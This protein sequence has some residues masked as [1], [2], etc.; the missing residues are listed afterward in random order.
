MLSGALA[1]AQSGPI[2][3]VYDELGRL[4]GVIDQNG[5][6][7]TYHYDAVGNLTGITRTSAGAVAIFEF[8][9]NAAPIGGPV[10]LYG[11]GFS[12]TPAQNAVTINGT[13]ATVTS[14]TTT[15]LVITVPAGATSGTLAVTT[16]TGSASATP[17]FPVAAGPAAPSISGI[18]PTIGLA[19]T[20]VTVSGSGFDPDPA[21]DKVSFNLSYGSPTS[22]TSTQVLV[23]LPTGGTSGRMTVATPYGTAASAQDFFVPPA[24]YV[25]T[26][27]LVTD[28]MTIGTDKVVTLGTASKIGLVVFDMSA[29]QRASLKIS[30][31]TT[32]QSAISVSDPYA[33]TVG[34]V[35]VATSG[36]FIEPF[37]APVAGSYT[38]IVDPTLTYT[39]S[40]TLHPYDVPADRSGAI[41]P[42]GAAVPFTIQAPGQNGRW[43][44]TGTAGQR[45]SMRLSNST[46]A[47]TY[48]TIVGPNSSTLVSQTSSSFIDAIVLPSSGTYT[49]FVDPQ[50]LSTGDATLTLY[51][52]P[53][54]ASGTITA[55]GAA[56][57]LTMSTPGQNGVLTF[58][59][60]AGQRF[61]LTI[62]PGPLASVTMRKPDGSTLASG[63]VGVLTAF[64]EPQTLPV[65]GTYSIFV[66]MSTFTTGSVTL[67]L[68]DVPADVSGSITIGGASQTVTTTTPGQNGS[69]TF[70]GTLAQRVSLSLSSGPG[71]SVSIRRAS[72]SSLSST[73]ITSLAGFIEPVTLPASETYSVFVDYTG[74]GTGSV[75]VQLFDVPPDVTGSVTVGGSALGVTTTTPGQNASITFSGTSG[76]QATVHLTGNTMGLT[77]VKL[78]KPDGSQLT[79]SSSSSSS[80]NLSTQTLPTTGTYT[81]VID[82]TKAGTGTINVS[83]TNP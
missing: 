34:S 36:G 48:L 11:I 13:A 45:I 40:A 41:V 43:T 54:D 56:Q 32:T 31:V 46:I 49:V 4:I 66:D 39:G 19:G 1:L 37:R 69:L 51:D 68:H 61:S 76:Q 44:F 78:L 25:A 29:G 70:S 73:S 26:D 81:I 12:A 2:R 9:P 52:V 83:V 77:A 82:P 42:G 50:T 14:A 60:T 7:A 57:T 10:T 67:T 59:G 16:P 18:S 75:T 27:V 65:T 15:T 3:Y 64:I 35:T 5:D 38:V 30:S 24:P 8:T 55:G 33:R 72:G 71:G 74:N 80:F 53:A 22:I 17:S 6:A 63:W 23:P 62:N 47:L 21:N 28:R 20:A 58:T 79:T